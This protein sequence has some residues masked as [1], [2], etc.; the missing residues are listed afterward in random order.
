MGYKLVLCAMV[1]HFNIADLTMLVG[2]WYSYVLKAHL[3]N[4]QN[5]ELCLTILQKKIKFKCCLCVY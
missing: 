3:D 1:M 5:K 2:I 4:K